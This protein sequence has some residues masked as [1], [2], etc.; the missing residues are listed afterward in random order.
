MA[1]LGAE[2]QA[3]A[4]ANGFSLLLKSPKETKHEVQEKQRSVFTNSKCSNSKCRKDEKVR[5]AREREHVCIHKHYYLNTTPSPHHHTPTPRNPRPKVLRVPQCPE[6]YGTDWM[7]ARSDSKMLYFARKLRRGV[8]RGGVAR[9][10]DVT[11]IYRGSRLTAHFSA[12]SGGRR[13][14]SGWL[15]RFAPGLY[16]LRCH[17]WER[18]TVQVGRP[19]RKLCVRTP[20]LNDTQFLRNTS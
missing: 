1:P 11:P 20:S 16:P 10:S 4:R 15:G 14:Y 2:D 9:L 12:G 17:T 6:G 13:P 18:W 7:E 3:T 8:T 5:E 19:N